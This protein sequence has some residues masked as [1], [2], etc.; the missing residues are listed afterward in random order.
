MCQ[1]VRFPMSRDH[2]F[3]TSPCLEGSDE[4]MSSPSPPEIVVSSPGR[5]RH[6][7][8]TDYRSPRTTMAASSFA[9]L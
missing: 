6:P 7:A 1:Q 5:R 4:S 2:P 3:D 8:P 9:R